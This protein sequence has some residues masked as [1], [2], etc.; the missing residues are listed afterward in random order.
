[1][2]VPGDIS[3]SWLF[4]IYNVKNY[5]ALRIEGMERNRVHAM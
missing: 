1:M 3:S 2:N 4:H 5:P